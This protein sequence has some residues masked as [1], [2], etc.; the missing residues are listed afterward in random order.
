[1][2]CIHDPLELLAILCKVEWILL[3][4]S[5]QIQLCKNSMAD[6]LIF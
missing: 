5:R 4:N 3:F 2:L 1:M 6:R